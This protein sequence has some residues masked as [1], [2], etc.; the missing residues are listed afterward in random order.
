MLRGKY[1]QDM[2]APFQQGV[3]QVG[4]ADLRGLIGKDSYR[5]SFEQGQ[6][7]VE[8]VGAGK[9]AGQ[10]GKKGRR[11]NGKYG[12][13]RRVPEGGRDLTFCK[14]GLQQESENDKG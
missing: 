13:C 2:D 4:I 6:V 9:D 3:D 8:L 14:E 1:L 7:E 12:R 5:L 10:R 11:R